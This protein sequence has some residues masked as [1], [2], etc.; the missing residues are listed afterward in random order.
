MS[1]LKH[2]IISWEAERP[3]GSQWLC[4]LKQTPTGSYNIP[5]DLSL[6][7][8]QNNLEEA[9][10]TILRPAGPVSSLRFQA[11]ELENS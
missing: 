9:F 3:D 10:L 1:R 4:E 6:T 2:F 8:L 11:V 7:D 5:P